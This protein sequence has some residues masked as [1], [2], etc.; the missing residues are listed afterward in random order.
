MI[1]T[2]GNRKKQRLFWLA[3][4]ALCIAIVIAMQMNN[5]LNRSNSGQSD[6]STTALTPSPLTLLTDPFLQ[7]PTDSSV[8]VVWFTEFEG[9]QHWVEYG[10]GQTAQAMTTQLSR[11]RE[12]SDSRV[13]G[14][15]FPQVTRR[16][17]WRHEAT[18]NH[19]QPGHRLPYRVISRNQDEQTAAS[20]SF[21]LASN[22]P[23]NHPLK[24]LLTSDHQLKPMTP[25][26][27]QKVS[28]TI[29]RVDAVFFAGDLVNVP[30]RASEWFDDA[31]GLAFF[32][33]M[34]GRASYAMK[35]NGT[36]GSTQ[37]GSKVTYKGGELIQHAPLFPVIGNHE[38]MGRYST[39]AKLNS[40]FANTLPRDQVNRFYDPPNKAAAC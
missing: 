37:E 9:T 13:Q 17:I 5:L 12:D 35:G 15:A 7:R 24:I 39:A 2:F 3:I 27:L 40:Q 21:T 25:A 26:N 29:G 18:V 23:K 16:E 33:A 4:A 34:Q 10:A 6:S 20:K 1:G 19:L 8:Q 14:R 11:T 30:D 38:V 32:P 28:E 31:R 22:P 36:E